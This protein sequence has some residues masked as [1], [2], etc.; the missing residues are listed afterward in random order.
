MHQYFKHASDEERG[1]AMKLL[2]Y[3]N[4]RG[5]RIVLQDI[6]HPEAPGEMTALEA[7]TKAL[8][9]EKEVNKVNSEVKKYWKIFMIICLFLESVGSAPHSI[10]S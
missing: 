7:M 8:D 2:K 5:G 1:H 3:M 4:K 6:K 10:F 9:F